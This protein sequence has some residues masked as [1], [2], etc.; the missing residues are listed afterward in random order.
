MS[1]TLKNITSRLTASSHIA[2][3]TPPK[4]QSAVI[5]ALSVV[6]KPKVVRQTD[7][8]LEVLVGGTFSFYPTT[9]Q[10]LAREGVS[11]STSP[12]SSSMSQ[13]IFKKLG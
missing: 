2:A 12:E 8:E 9:L 11:V 3:A 10:L 4:W 1:D 6:R 13:I 5:K 7:T